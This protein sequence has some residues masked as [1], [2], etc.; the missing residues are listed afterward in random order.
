VEGR[1]TQTLGS[2][3]RDRTD[4]RPSLGVLVT[5]SVIA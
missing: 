2:D 5:F 4:Q 3:R 1:R